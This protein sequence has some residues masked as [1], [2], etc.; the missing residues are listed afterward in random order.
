[1]LPVL[2]MHTVK[3]QPGQV[4][5]VVVLD[6]LSRATDDVRLQTALLMHVIILDPVLFHVV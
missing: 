1:M 5:K 4:V 3:M 6:K 2:A